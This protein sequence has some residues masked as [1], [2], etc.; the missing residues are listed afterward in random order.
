MN[1]RPLPFE[2][3][4]EDE[5]SDNDNL[6]EEEEADGNDGEQRDYITELEVVQYASIM[7]T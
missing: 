4:D 2:L 7:Y 3:V 5:C 1:Q 6:D